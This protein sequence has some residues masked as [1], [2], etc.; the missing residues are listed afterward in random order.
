MKIHRMIR[1][2]LQ[3]FSSANLRFVF[4]NRAELM[5]NMMR[6]QMPGQD[7]NSS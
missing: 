2:L 5:S 3:R 7:L 4:I 1:T 6:V